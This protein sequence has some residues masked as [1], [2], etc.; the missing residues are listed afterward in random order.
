MTSE[1]SSNPEPKPVTTTERDDAA[2]IGALEAWYNSF[3]HDG[4]EKE[5]DE[6]LRI[7]RALQG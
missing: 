5:W 3:P 7:V 2:L 4:G 1:P 6:L